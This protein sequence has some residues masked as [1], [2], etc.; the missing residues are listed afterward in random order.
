MPL[1]SR[2]H[3]SQPLSISG[4]SS[5]SIGWR[6]DIFEWKPETE[7]D[8][9]ATPSTARVRLRRCLSESALKCTLDG[10]IRTL[11]LTLT[12]TLTSEREAPYAE[13]RDVRDLPP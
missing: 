3:Q 7:S 11:T 13:D 6:S 5:P 4:K 9:G 1:T 12:L 8:G 2:T 10:L